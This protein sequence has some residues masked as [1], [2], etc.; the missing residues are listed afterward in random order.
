[1]KNYVKF[2]TNK[3]HLDNSFVELEGFK[4]S[5]I[6]RT[7]YVD[8]LQDS[9]DLKESTFKAGKYIQE[10][11]KSSIE[12]IDDE[13]DYRILLSLYQSYISPR[14]TIKDLNSLNSIT[15]DKD[16]V[17][18]SLN[19]DIKIKVD[20]YP[21]EIKHYNFMLLNRY[22]SD[23]KRFINTPHN[24]ISLNDL[25]DIIVDY[26][27]Q[28]TKTDI[29]VLD[30]SY[31]KE[32]SYNLIT[33]I[34]KNASII[35]AS[36]KPK[37]TLLKIALVGK[38]VHFDTGGYSLKPSD[39][40]IDMKRDKTGAITAM[41]MYIL[42]VRLNLPIE[43][44]LIIG[45]AEN[46]LSPNGYKPGDVLKSKNHKTIEVINTDAEGRLLLA[47]CLNYLSTLDKD[48]N[49]IITIATLTGAAMR[50]VS[51]YTVAEHGSQTFHDNT[52]EITGDVICNLKPHPKL[53][54]TLKSKIAD[55]RNMSKTTEAG[56]ITAY[57]FLKEF[58]PI[59][60]RLQYSHLD[61]AGPSYTDKLFGYT[62]YGATG[63]LLET[64]FIDAL[65]N[66][67]WRS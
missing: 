54:D 32:N 49:R 42:A 51:K 61:I 8:P 56:S 11:L 22:L 30:S 28:N 12:L 33:A 9:L 45:L 59:I 20:D 47:D 10:K 14:E 44:D 36:Y 37:T 26:L 64:F 67:L 1:M 57:L 40:M 39:T 5:P 2:T 3:D 7:I 65:L 16:I 58:V 53:K 15:T 13:I 55:L 23:L 25:R 43:I 38:G 21:I 34:D 6:A 31:L 52:L 66:Y 19:K 29:K 62:D 17:K 18:I 48:F 4:Y 27:N 41:M 60:P 63:I 46:L 35:H 50:A 24:Q